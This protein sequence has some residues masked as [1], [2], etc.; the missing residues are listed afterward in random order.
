MRVLLL[1]DR[2]ELV[3]ILLR[4]LQALSVTVERYEEGVD[5]MGAARGAE[6]ILLP[7]NALEEEA[8]LLARALARKGASSKSQVVFVQGEGRLI[9]SVDEAR[10][11]GGHH[12]WLQGSRFRDKIAQV[13]GLDTGAVALARP[14]SS[15][16]EAER[17]WEKLDEVRSLDYFTILEIDP[18]SSLHQRSQTFQRLSRTFDPRR[19]AQAELIAALEEIQASLQD[20]YFVLQ[21]PAR[22]NTY[23]EALQQADL[24]P[25]TTAAPLHL[26]QNLKALNSED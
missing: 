24:A 8:V 9:E 12:F 14:R 5:L 4:E 1:D 20:A 13:L 3:G 16:V 23:L 2:S 11:A 25:P 26:E 15:Q 10:R 6:L 21:H 7:L 19:C 17:V 22:A 18:Y